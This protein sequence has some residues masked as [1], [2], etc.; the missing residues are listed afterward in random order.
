MLSKVRL[1]TQ[2]GWP[3]DVN[4]ELKPYATRHYELTVEAGC[5]LWGMRVV[6]PD[7]CRKDVLCELH[8]S[9]PGIV[10]MKSLA[11]VHVWWPGIDKCIEQLVREC[12]TCQSV[13]NNP[14][15]TLLHLWSW[16]DAPWKRIHVD[17]AGPFQGSMFMVIVDAHSKW[18]EV[19]PMSTIMTEKTLDVV[20]SMFA[21]YGLPEQLVS[22]NGPQ[23]ISS[24]F[25]RFMKENGI[26][27]IRTSP[28]HP[29]SNG[30]AE[31]FIQ[32]FK[33]Y[34]KA[35]KNDSG[36]LSTKLSRFLITYRNTPSSTTGVSPAELFM[37]RHL[38]TRL[39]LLRP[40]IQKRVQEKQA[41][42]KRYHD[43]HSKYRE[44]DIGQSVL[45]R[46]LRDGA[47]W[48]PDTIYSGAYWTCIV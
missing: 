42:Q 5:L 41:D 48:I 39:D 27:H 13:R 25:E 33:N 34:L 17:F 6:V 3:N 15:L 8:T 18:L 31:R 16:P 2:R 29:A 11:R 47:K 45:V 10:K 14:S 7:S 28:Y 19:V 36:S 46:N 30:E 20:R 43:A 37:K 26:K 21:R 23:F 40:S 44:F 12:E 24:E 1:Y 38:R 22:D 35:S 4:P 32:T 9:H